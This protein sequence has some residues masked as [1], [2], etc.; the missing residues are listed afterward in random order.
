MCEKLFLK[1]V[2]EYTGLRCYIRCR[3]C[4]GLDNKIVVECSL[5][6]I[7]ILVGY[8]P[9]PNVQSMLHDREYWKGGWIQKVIAP[10][11]FSRLSR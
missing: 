7:Y 2:V 10:L 11:S 8:R 3:L 4:R 5:L 9:Y 1:K 6:I